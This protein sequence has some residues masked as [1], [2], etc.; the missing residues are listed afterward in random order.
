[1]TAVNRAG[2]I[3]CLGEPLVCFASSPGSSLLDSACAE[4]SEGGAEFNVAVHLARLGN[5]VRFVGAVGDDVLGHR[6]RA[7][8]LH[9]GV[10]TSAL[11]QHP[12][13][14][15]GA[16][17]KDWTVKGRN[18]VYLREGSA[19][20]HLSAVSPEALRDVTHL[21]L[22]GITPALS[23]QCA[24]LVDKLMS[25]PR[26]YTVSFDVNYREKLWKADEA[27]PHL[28]RIAGAADLVLVGQDEAQ[29]LWD[30]STADD[31]RRRLA[32]PAELVIKHD[33]HEAVAWSGTF[34][35]TLAPTHVDVTEPVGA[36][37]AFA[38]GYIYGRGRGYSPRAALAAGHRL[39]SAALQ[40]ADDLGA[41]VPVDDL[42][43][44]LKEN[45]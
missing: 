18:V 28:A 36:G 9:E 41:P 13:E 17:V 27:A 45:R 31:I 43:R 8:L 30:T 6:I 16:Y 14:R 34:R 24:R 5:T 42:E 37:D 29:Q 35:V 11:Q 15:T 20:S 1:M 12:D 40:A 33:D 23:D 2:V 38:A 26:S 7:R 44:L 19:A 10:D 32:E 21:H 3:A 4:V 39:A 25:R 22:S